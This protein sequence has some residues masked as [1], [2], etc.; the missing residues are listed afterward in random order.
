MV[1]K[2]NCSF[3]GHAIEPGTGKMYIKKDGTVFNFCSNKCKKNNI[4]LGRVSRRTRWT[5]RY[6]ELKAST[7]SREKGPEEEPEEKPE[8]E[9]PKAKPKKAPAKK[10]APKKKEPAEKSE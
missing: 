9:K 10:A 5:T 3:C 6:G 4:G 8:E 7:L 1:E 2:R